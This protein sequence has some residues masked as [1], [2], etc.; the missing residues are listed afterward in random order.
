MTANG[1]DESYQPMT[2]NSTA[3]VSTNREQDEFQFE[4]DAAKENIIVKITMV[5][6]SLESDKSIRLVSGVLSWWKQ[7]N[8]K[9]DKHSLRR[10]I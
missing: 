4:S 6:E 10:I 8:T 1:E 7:T 2:F 5:Y 3:Y 9:K